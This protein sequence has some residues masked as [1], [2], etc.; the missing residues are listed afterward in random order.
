MH[1]TL[2]ACL[3]AV[4][5]LLGC[6]DDPLGPTGGAGG[7]GSSE[8][9]A[10][11][12]GGASDGGS[13]GVGGDASGGGGAEPVCKEYPVSWTF[14]DTQPAALADLQSLT[15]GATMEWSAQHG[16]LQLVTNMSVPLD[17]STDVWTGLFSIVAAHPDLFQIDRAEWADEPPFPCSAVPNTQIVNTNRLSLAGDEV[18]KDVFAFFVAP[19]GGGG[20]NLTGVSGFYLPH[21]EPGDLPSCA[22]APDAELEAT[23]RSQSFA[24]S[25]FDLCAPTGSGTYTPAEG[26]VVTLDEIYWEWDDAEVGVLARKSRRGTLVIDPSHYTDEMLASNLNCPDPDDPSGD[27]R[28]LGFSLTFDAVTGEL[29]DASPGIGC[30]V[31]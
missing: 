3:T 11:G 20:V 5:T 9:G 14:P 6:G 24:F 12:H 26:D 27:G 1:R 21:L 18:R 19:D 16:T 30:I 8:G 13:V 17:C 28:I 23:V 10:I 15:E 7:G 22:N 31:C 2:I 29:L 4:A 25:T